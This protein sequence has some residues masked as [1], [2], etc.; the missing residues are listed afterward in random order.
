MAKWQRRT[1]IQKK[2]PKE[3]GLRKEKRDARALV[4]ACSRSSVRSPVC[5]CC[6]CAFAC[7]SPKR[8]LL[9]SSAPTFP[10]ARAGEIPYPFGRPVLNDPFT[11]R[12]MSPGQLVY[13][14][15]SADPS[16]MSQERIFL[17]SKIDS[18]CYLVG[19]Y[20]GYIL[21]FHS[22]NPSYPLIL[23]AR[24]Q[25]NSKHYTYLRSKPSR[26]KELH[27]KYGKS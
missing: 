13:Q 1:P 2:R 5:V 25:Q 21:P 9:S 10:F 16:A 24:M 8:A 4:I 22:A 11:I 3:R 6:S 15:E 26:T 14:P 20:D 17:R 19:R 7:S 12:P 27:Q 18:C 23:W